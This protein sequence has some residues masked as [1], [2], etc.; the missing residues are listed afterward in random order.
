[1]YIHGVPFALQ[2]LAFAPAVGLI[3]PIHVG[4]LPLESNWD[5]LATSPTEFFIEVGATEGHFFRDELGARLETGFLITF[6]PHF[7]RY[8]RVMTSAGVGSMQFRALGWQTNR[9]MILPFALGCSNAHGCST[10]FG[11][12]TAVGKRGWQRWARRRCSILVD[13]V[14]VPCLSLADVINHWLRGHCVAAMKLSSHPLRA[15]QSLGALAG[16]VEQIYL[17]L[18]AIQSECLETLRTLAVLGFVPRQGGRDVEVCATHQELYKIAEFRQG[19]GSC[20]SSHSP[21]PGRLQR[22][23]LLQLLVAPLQVAPVPFSKN[24]AHLEAPTEFMLE[25]GT[26][27]VILLRDSL[28]PTDRRFLLSFEPLLDKYADLITSWPSVVNSDEASTIGAHYS[29]GVMLPYAVGCPASDEVALFHVGLADVCSSL[30]NISEGFRGQGWSHW[31]KDLK[32]T[33]AKEMDVRLVPCISL[34]TVIRDWL[35]GGHISFLKIDAQ[36][37]DLDVVRSLGSQMHKV[38]RIQME[39][40]PKSHESVYVNQPMCDHIVAEMMKLGFKPIC[41]LAGSKNWTIADI[42]SLQLKGEGDL[43][44]YRQRRPLNAAL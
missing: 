3:A 17:Q 38:R 19:R 11:V 44:F 40:L 16:R 39:A 34:E 18:P 12:T 20:A 28:P 21:L 41:R 32:D 2:W 9:S 13:G 8:L 35:L 1:M 43:T 7:G 37:K 27:N 15:L 5:H 26:N 30:L 42:C 14:S 23:E 25:V 31:F 29:R 36:G 33:C 6:E 22:K 4:R 24:W 10:D